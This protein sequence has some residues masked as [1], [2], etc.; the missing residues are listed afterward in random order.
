[1]IYGMIESSEPTHSVHCYNS[2]AAR[3]WEADGALLAD[4]FEQ[5]L[6]GFGYHFTHPVAVYSRKGCI[7]ILT[8]RDGMSYDEAMEYFDFNVQGA[9]V[10]E[11]TP[12]FLDDE[13]IV[14]GDE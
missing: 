4:G 1:M 8:S 9:W 11:N 2:Q 7:D 14:E 13:Y 6:V 12:I 3:S 5:A 10:G